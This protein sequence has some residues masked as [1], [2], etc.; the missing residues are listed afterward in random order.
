MSRE[1]MDEDGS[2]EQAGVDNRRL[3]DSQGCQ[4]LG[5]EMLGLHAQAHGQGQCCRDSF[6]GK[7]GHRR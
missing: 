1:A 6:H 7:G 4:A 3:G 5:R 2:R